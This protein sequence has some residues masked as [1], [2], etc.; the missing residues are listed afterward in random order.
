MT[1]VSLIAT[2]AAPPSPTGEEL[3]ALPDSVDWLEVRS[4]LVGDLDPEWLRRHFG[5]R[6]VYALRSQAEGGK[7]AGSL[8]QRHPRMDAAARVYDRIDLEASRDLSEHLLETIPAEK[9]CVAWHGPASD[10]PSLQTRFEQLSLIP[11]AL[12]K[13][14]THTARI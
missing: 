14:V 11:A 3:A 5:G 6:L 4:D 13:I 2:L 8:G 12:Y 9:R 7:D 1:R 10:L